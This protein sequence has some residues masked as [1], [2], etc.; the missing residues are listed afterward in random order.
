MKISNPLETMLKKREEK[1]KKYCQKK[2]I[3]CKNISIGIMRYFKECSKY[4]YDAMLVFYPDKI[5][6]VYKQKLKFYM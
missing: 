1:F 6:L 2:G 3:L 4:L 5:K